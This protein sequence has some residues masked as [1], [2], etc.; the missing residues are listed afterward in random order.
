MAAGVDWKSLTI[1]ACLPITTDYFPDK[2]SL[3]N[4]YVLSD[5][6]LLPDDVNLDYANNR[7]V[8]R[9]PL[10]TEEVFT[11]IVS[12]RLAQG[13]QLI[14]IEDKTNGSPCQS[15]ALN[16]SVD[17]NRSINSVL[18]MK[19]LQSDVISKEYIL[20]IGRIFHKITLNGSVI[21]VT[22]YRPRSLFYYICKILYI[23]EILLFNLL[24]KMH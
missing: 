14:N 23:I 2:R 8:Y 24:I 17:F 7:A 18:N 10:S 15:Q 19:N 3:H 11:E 12:Q 1:P 20:S 13:F 5:Y 4:D 6:T 16:L 9:K 22:G 21:T